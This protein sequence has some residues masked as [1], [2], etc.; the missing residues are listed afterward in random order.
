MLMLLLTHLAFVVFLIT[1]FYIGVRMVMYA[2]S[3]TNEERKLEH[4]G[5]RLIG[6]III[7]LVVVT[8]S[9]FISTF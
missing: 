3:I 9:I 1:S 2:N 5:F 8:A 7:L 6:G 4:N